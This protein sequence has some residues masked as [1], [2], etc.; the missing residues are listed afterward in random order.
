MTPSGSGQHEWIDGPIETIQ[1]EPEHGR[2][3]WCRGAEREA[4]HGRTAKAKKHS[5]GEYALDREMPFMD[6]L[7]LAP[8]LF[9]TSWGPARASG[10]KSF[11]DMAKSYIRCRPTQVVCGPGGSLRF[12]LT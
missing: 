6:S 5:R 8:S 12:R 3:L 11:Q 9:Y 2:E 4:T 1:P 7:G 10:P